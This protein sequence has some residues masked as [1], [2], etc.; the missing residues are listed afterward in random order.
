MARGGKTARGW[1]MPT[2]SLESRR[3]LGADVDLVINIGAPQG[4]PLGGY[5]AKNSAAANPP[6]RRASARGLWCRATASRCWSVRVAIDAVAE[7]AQDT[8]PLRTGALGT[9]WPSTCS[10]CAF[11]RTVS[12][13]SALWR[14]PDRRALFEAHADRFFDDRR[15]FRRHRRPMRWKT[16]ERFARHQ[17]GTRTAAGRVA[18]PRGAAKLMPQPSHI[19]GRHPC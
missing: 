6:H 4:P 18:N 1:L 14:S 3:R 11:R 8:P 9:C 17:A 13:R 5:E 7:N 19:V 10:A 2:S 12:F 15:R 16:Y